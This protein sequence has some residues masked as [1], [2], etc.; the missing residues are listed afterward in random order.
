MCIRDSRNRGYIIN[1]RGMRKM[2]LQEVVRFGW[3]F[4]VEKKDPKGFLDWLKLLRR[5]AR[6]DFRRP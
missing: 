2:Q 4:L 3:F 6:E 1:Q 5:G